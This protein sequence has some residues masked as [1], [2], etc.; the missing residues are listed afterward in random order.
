MRGSTFRLRAPVARPPAKRRADRRRLRLAAALLLGLCGTPGAS[1]AAD[2]PGWK[3]TWQDEFDGDRIDP[4]KWGHDLGNGFYN[5]DAGQWI[6]GWGNDELQYYTRDPDNAFVKDGML[7]I[8]AIKESIDG[9][10]YTS[11]RL[12]TRRKDGTNL[13]SQAYG[14]FEV[15]AKLPLGQGIWPALWLLPEKEQYGGWAAS[16]EI[17]ILE[18]KGQ[19]PRRI[20]GAIHYGGRWPANAFAVGE[21][22]FDEGSIAEFHVY[23]VDWDPGAIHWEVDGTRYASK[24]FWWSTSKSNAK[25]GINPVAEADLEPWPAPFDRPFQI[26]MNLA[27]GGRFLG[28]PDSTTPFPAEMLV[29]YVRVYEREGGPAPLATRGPGRLPFAPAAR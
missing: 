23:A 12:R 13:F 9:F 22:V 24:N 11:A 19:E 2:P 1:P 17:D 15:R 16:G 3:L 29:D 25:G 21:H 5:Y 20:Q 28:N 8:R 26:L 27:V 4:A 10:G 14:R 7:H 18:T 6:G